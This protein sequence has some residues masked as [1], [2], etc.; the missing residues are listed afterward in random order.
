VNTGH[1]IGSL[2]GAGTVDLGVNV[3]GVNVAAG[4][5]LGLGNS[6][7]DTGTTTTPT[8][9]QAPA[10]PTVDVGGLLD[11]LLRRRK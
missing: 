6:S 9:P 3:A 10:T 5:D 2:N 8:T 11:G 7:S 1:T 4:V